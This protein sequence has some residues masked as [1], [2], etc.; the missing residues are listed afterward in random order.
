MAK[1]PPTGITPDLAGVRA[2][3]LSLT[4]ELSDAALRQLLRRLGLERDDVAQTLFVTDY[5]KQ[6]KKHE[7]YAYLKIHDPRAIY[8]LYDLVPVD[9]G[10]NAKPVVELF[11]ALTKLNLQVE[12]ECVAN[13]EYS[14]TAWASLVTLPWQPVQMPGLPFDEFRGFRAV[15]KRNGDVLYH[16]IVDCPANKEISHSISFSYPAK[17]DMNLPINLLNRAVEVSRL[18]VMPKSAT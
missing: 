8:V 15:K 16:V 12:V 6:R 2:T 4:I 11:S 9:V 1:R 7:A 10:P 18:F 17:L 13:F 14:E 3:S 5:S